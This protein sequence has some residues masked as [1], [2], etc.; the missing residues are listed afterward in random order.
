MDID[1]VHILRLNAGVAQGVHHY[2]VSAFAFFCRLRNVIRISA[3]AVADDLGH[4]RRA[5]PAS[6]LQIFENEDAGAF[7]DRAIIRKKGGDLDGAIAD[8]DRAVTL[9]P[10]KPLIRYNR[11]NAL[12][13]TPLCTAE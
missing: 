8:Y 5:A 3:H 10:D 12:K 13:A 7:M 4:D 6:E 2:A 1:V 9:A 11:A